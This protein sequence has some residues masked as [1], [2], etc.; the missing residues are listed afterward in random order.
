MK[1]VGRNCILKS[2]K[3]KIM[4]KT[5]ILMI[6][7]VF[8]LASCFL[9]EDG[10]SSRSGGGEVP[11]DDGLPDAYE[12]SGK[13]YY[14]MDLYGM[15]ARAD[16]VDLFVHVLTMDL[17]SESDEGMK[18][19]KAALD[20]VVAAFLNVGIHVHFDVGTVNCLYDGADLVSDFS[21]Y[22]LGSTVSHIVTEYDPDTKYAISLSSDVNSGN[23]D[24]FLF[25]DDLR[26]NDTYFPDNSTTIDGAAVNRNYAFYLMV[27]GGTQEDDGD[28]GSSGL[29]WLGGRDF[30]TAL[31]GWELH[32]NPT[33]DESTI[34]I[35][36]NALKN[37]VANYQASTIMHE[38][39]HNLGLRHGG[40][41]ST[42]YKPNYNSIMNYLYQLEGLPDIGNSEG[43][44]Y[45]F[46]RLKYANAYS[47]SYSSWM[48]LL[49]TS[50]LYKGYYYELE[51]GL[52]N[53]PFS[54]SF[55]MNYSHGYGYDLNE[56]S[57]NEGSG[58]RQDGSGSVDWN[59][60]GSITSGVTENINPWNDSD[61][62]SELYDYDDWANLEYYYYNYA[63][64][65]RSILDTEVEFEISEEYNKHTSSLP[66]L[67]L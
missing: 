45:Y 14:G 10:G 42:N 29:S 12:V 25:V 24:V 50:Y 7:S 39:G 58:L 56:Y 34:G 1:Q 19:Q 15:G 59:G 6:A 30:L 62:S 33:T 22:N 13:T 67:E 20:K 27:I 9:F 52:K 46:D 16:Q 40:D 17:S 63:G 37:Y 55:N 49:D 18:L 3:V 54:D 8:V 31:K 53:G 57:L 26:E 32:F 64:G 61:Y 41:V 43:D 2:M 44:R 47:Q 4:R 36:E 23:D 48:A 28:D 65:G 11:Q 5:I 35:D 60:S 21:D 38:F 51:Y 66:D